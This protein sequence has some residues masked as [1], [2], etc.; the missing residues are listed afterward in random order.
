MLAYIF[1]SAWPAVPP[2]PLIRVRFASYDTSSMRFP[3]REQTA[4][5][6]YAPESWAKRYAQWLEGHPAGMGAYE[7][8]FTS[9]P[10]MF[11]EAAATNMQ[12]LARAGA[13]SFHSQTQPDTSRK[14]IESF[15]L[16]ST[17]WDMNAMD[18]WLISRLMWDPFQPVDALRATFIRRLYGA[19][20]PEM[21]AYYE[22]FSRAWF[23]RGNTAFVNCHTPAG[24]VYETFIVAPGLE[25]P[26]RD[27]LAAAVRKAAHP[28][29]RRHLQQKLAAYDQM[30]ASLGRLAVPRVDEIA[31][32]WE[33]GGS[34]QWNRAFAAAT[35]RDALNFDY[36][37]NLA[38]NHTEVRL[39]HDTTH[40]YFRLAASGRAAADPAAPGEHY[41]MDDRVEFIFNH[42]EKRARTL[43]AVGADG[44]SADLRNWD[45]RFDAGW[46][47]KPIHV[48]EGWGAVGRI[49]LAAV[50][51]ATGTSLEA[52]LIRVAADGEESYFRSDTNRSTTHPV[53]SPHTFSRYALADG[54]H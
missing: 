47:T 1:T 9:I 43:F 46:Q 16:N 5:A 17:L 35:F 40:L 21:T 19:A 25:Q 10:A 42:A 38:T 41:P 8:F 23:N 24:K 33:D 7:Y 4:P 29:T 50:A 52:V 22:Q 2:H 37:S 54:G 53:G 15:G 3:L 12:D 26:L 31:G 48:A 11:A 49:P 34:P 44:A 28:A 27:L 45:P 30:G 13:A 6:T 39:M 14:S 20:A 32:E 18:Q 51:D 36:A